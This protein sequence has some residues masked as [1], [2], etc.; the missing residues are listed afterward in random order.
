[1]PSTVLFTVAAPTGCPYARFTDAG[2]S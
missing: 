1:V 2:F